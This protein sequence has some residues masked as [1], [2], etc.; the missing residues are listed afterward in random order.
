MP[1]PYHSCFRRGSCR[2]AL[3]LLLGWLGCA[4][5]AQAQPQSLVFQHLTTTEGLSHDAAGAIVQDHQ[6]FIWIGTHN[7]LNRYDGHTVRHFYHDPIDSTSLNNN[8]ITALHVD[9]QGF[10]WV[11]TNGGGLHR[12]D[13]ATET[14]A[15]IALPRTQ[16][17]ETV[18]E[19][20]LENEDGTLWLGSWER[21]LWHLDPATGALK[22]YRHDP[23]DP[24]SLGHDVVKDLLPNPDGT[25]WVATYAGLSHFDPLTGRS[26]R[27]PIPPQQVGGQAMRNQLAWAVHRDRRGQIWVGTFGGLYRFAPETGTYR[28]YLHDPGDPNT[29]GAPIIRRILEDRDGYLWL[30]LSNGLDRFDAHTET[31]VHIRHDPLIPSRLADGAVNSLFLDRTG[32]LW[33]STDRGGVSHTDLAARRI[34][35]HHHHPGHPEGL[36]P[37]LVFALHEDA[38]G[39]LWLAGEAGLSRLDRRAGGA[40]HFTP[41]AHNLPPGTLSDLA[42][43]ASGRL[44]VAS[45]G[46]GVGRQRADGTFERFT[47][48]ERGHNNIYHLNPAAEGGFWVGTFN[49]L[50]HWQPE[51]DTR[52]PF[53][54]ALPGLTEDANFFVM[55]LHQDP[56]G[57]V[58]L[59]YTTGL[60]R[61]DPA[62]GTF[63]HYRHD[64]ADT[65]SL[66]PN[67]VSVLHTDR[68]GA[69]WTAGWGGLSRFDPATEAFTR[70][71]L[72]NG[73][74][75]TNGIY[76][77]LEDDAGVFWL[78]T[79]AG[80]LRFDPATGRVRNVKPDIVGMPSDMNY[81][82]VHKSTA[83]ELFF[84]VLDGYYAFDPA[85]L[86]AN[87]HPPSV[88]LTE[89]RVLDA[90]TQP[91]PG[92]RLEVALPVADRIRL[93]YGD[94][95]FAL[96]FSAMHFS[97]PAQN[98]YRFRLDGFDAAWR[99]PTAEPSVTYTNLD[100]G[101]YTFQVRA[102]NS[103]G[104]WS[105]ESTVL[106]VEITPP[107]WGTL[108]FQLLL[109]LGLAGLLLGAYS[110]RVHAIRHRNRLLAQQVE[111]RTQQIEAQRAT[112]E[113]QARKLL[114]TDAMKSNFF[115]NTSHELRTPLTLIRGNLED[116]T[117]DTSL[118]LNAQT[119]H[120]LNVALGQTQ[121]LQ[122]LVEQLL[123]LSRL[124]SNQLQ[125]R[126]QA[127]D[128]NPFLR[129]VVGAFE[130]VAQQRGLSLRF[131]G[132]DAPIR[133]Y[134]DPDKLEKIITNLLGNALKFT[135]QGGSVTVT[136]HDD[137]E[138]RDGTGQFATITVADT[139]DGIPAD[140][141]PHIFDRFYQ[142]DG[143]VTRTRE[144][145]GLG[146][147]LA[148]ELT[149]LHGG[150]LSVES[151]RGVGTTFLVRLPQGHAHLADHERTDALPR[152][153]HDPSV[154]VAA[155]LHEDHRV[156]D[157][158]DSE[159]AR[160]ETVLV[161]EDND[162]LRDYLCTHLRGPY[163]VVDAAE[164]ETGLALA[165]QHRPDLIVSDV[166]MPKM[167]GLT[168]LRA[169]KAD[170]DLATIPVML[171]TAKASAD[172]QLEG[173]EA[174]AAH[175]IA[176]PFDMATLKLRIQ[177]LLRARARLRAAFEQQG[178]MPN[179]ADLGLEAADA[180][181]LNDAQRITA[182]HVRDAGFNVEALAAALYVSESTL[183]RR[184]HELTGLSAAAFIRQIRLD[185][186]RQY[187]DAHAFRT[188]AELAAAVGF[189][190]A[191]YF[192]RLYERTFGESATERI[193]G[194]RSS[195]DAHS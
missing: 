161:V 1:S 89:L 30:G 133:L 119:W 158:P 145:M 102:A 11:A 6:G 49:G 189:N 138:D 131:V 42:V 60:S 184:L 50:F 52:R 2:A 22:N 95:L 186:A 83:G 127:D 76:G 113:A 148:R 120:R 74:L 175:Y 150:D 97:H 85:T 70:Y 25:L 193:R 104:V 90:V 174:E 132:T 62:T 29:L 192:A 55:G 144:G 92:G 91:Q 190:N 48:A 51:T 114:A 75:P 134:F 109:G 149:D 137:T 153:A 19:A 100:P 156:E 151:Q 7:G 17:R 24:F 77:L 3:A 121:R 117:A 124:Q 28:P 27:Y 147:A 154:G 103:D 195:P 35:H 69:L 16:D 130:S 178:R 98:R 172:D 179:A 84:G 45:I 36:Q 23:N 177:N 187:L 72:E 59:G 181:F 32:V 41:A 136:L 116:I 66:Q 61:L 126:A 96:D 188:L 39:F 57:R 12:Y 4:F 47:F 159:N 170:P 191:H 180:V 82:A 185:R 63:T 38:G 194:T 160:T 73:R 94:R 31:F 141:L 106:A 46:G 21:G 44:W 78:H 164:G 9:R 5:P 163:R 68:T 112:L 118:Q 58:W 8:G 139:G 169:L 140:A 166:M 135:E 80:L 143:S 171:L 64:P 15:R 88:T 53:R 40:Q 176:K 81:D 123:D 107:W 105:Q 129:R 13:P 157:V 122:Q 34:Q 128:L 168:L 108:W 14:F 79:N 165:Q 56:A 155:L 43:D 65:T 93:A 146:L 54:P 99:G 26:V 37:G 87:P 71:T 182:E 10:L 173:L 142:A 162:E 20:F 111:A 18:I 125:L 152:R 101:T 110:A 86:A 183:R 67:W 33:V 167:D 115:A